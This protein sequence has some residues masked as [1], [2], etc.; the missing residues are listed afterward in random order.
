MTLAG[1]EETEVHVV[2]DLVSE[3]VVVAAD[4]ETYSSSGAKFHLPW[5]FAV[6]PRAGAGAGARA[7][8]RAG[9][10]GL[11]PFGVHGSRARSRGQH[12]CMI[13]CPQHT[14]SHLG[15]PLQSCQTAPSLLA[16][17]A[18]FP[19]SPTHTSPCSKKALAWVLYTFTAVTM[20]LVYLHAT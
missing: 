20:L 12:G 18:S 15:K 17:V 19:G 6:K 1:L 4:T 9:H 7:G 2:L 16:Q 3:A 13:P 11:L 10:S 5:H 14:F 8:A